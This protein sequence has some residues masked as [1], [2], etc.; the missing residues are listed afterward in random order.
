MCA[1]KPEKMGVKHHGLRLDCLPNEFRRG[2][3][4]L[5]GHEPRFED[6]F[7]IPPTSKGPYTK[8]SQ[9]RSSPRRERLTR[10]PVRVE[11]GRHLSQVDRVRA[12]PGRRSPRTGRRGRKPARFDRLRPTIQPVR[13]DVDRPPQDLE[14]FGAPSA[15]PTRHARPR[16]DSSRV[17]N[18]PSALCG[19]QLQQPT[20][21]CRRASLAMQRGCGVI[22][23]NHCGRLRAGLPAAR[24]W[25][26]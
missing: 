2:T 25:G 21:R 20:T 10:I 15:N 7:R 14:R 26:N 1:V 6:P 22:A 17:I 18:R 9:R 23:D 13:P 24:P 5:V 16:S 11:S 19:S 8:P 12:I 3:Q 4:L